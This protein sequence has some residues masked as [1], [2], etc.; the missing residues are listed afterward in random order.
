MT[1]KIDLKDLHLL[2]SASKDRY[3]RLST[4]LFIGGK[5]V[6]RGYLASIANFE[7]FLMYL[8]SK[9][10]LTEFVEF[11]YNKVFD[12]NDSEDLEERK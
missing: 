11:D 12:D 4:P 2:V 6:E 3:F 5:E 10:L 9:G 8:N 7:A 1:Y